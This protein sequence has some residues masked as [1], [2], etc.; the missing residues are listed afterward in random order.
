MC[1]ECFLNKNKTLHTQRKF[2]ISQNNN[3]INKCFTYDSMIVL[4]NKKEV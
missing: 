2:L 4:S 3:L 1:N